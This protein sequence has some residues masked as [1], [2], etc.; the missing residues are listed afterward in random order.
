MP[1]KPCGLCGQP[2]EAAR[3]SQKYCSDDCRRR[4]KYN[5]DRAWLARHPEKAKAYSRKWY[6]ENKVYAL[7]DKKDA[8]RAKCAAAFKQEDKDK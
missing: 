4:V 2:F 7:A 5:N 3:R 8:Y 6:A 1:M